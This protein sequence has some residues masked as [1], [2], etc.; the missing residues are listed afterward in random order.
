MTSRPDPRAEPTGSGS[1][2]PHALRP[3][4]EL[5]RRCVARFLELEGVD[6][7]MAL[8][9]QGFAALLPLLIVISAASPGDGRDVADTLI[10]EFKLS[11]SAEDALR[12][13]LSRPAGPDS[14]LGI[15]SFLVLAISALSFTRA[16]QRLYVRAWRL[17]SMGLRGNA[18]GLAWL[19][20][21]VVWGSIQPVI[22]S[23]FDGVAAFVVSEALVTLLWLITPWLLVG[24]RLPW[25]TLVFQALL[26]AAG[27]LALSVSAAV[28][29]PRAVSSAAADFGVIG[30]AFALLTLLFC[31]A[32]VFV[33]AAAIGATLAEWREE[34]RS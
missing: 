23:L 14:S 30:V 27:L 29:A 26:T 20:A 7:A 17:P 15:V 25:R 10:E 11:G 24:R 13:A 5:G 22:V 34:R 18:W 2:V 28:Y 6:R 3:L 33:G 4:V 12:S 9:G 19:A 1:R 21:F 8:A 16:M 32:A 31:V